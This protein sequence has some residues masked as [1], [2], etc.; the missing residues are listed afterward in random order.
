MF[1]NSFY[2]YQHIRCDTNEIIYVGKGIGKRAYDFIR[3][4]KLWLDI[5]S[6]TDIKVEMLI[7]NIE[8][9]FAILIEKE[10]ISSYLLKNISLVNIKLGG[11]SNKKYYHSEEV[12][13]KMSESHKGKKRPLEVMEKMWVANR[14]KP[15]SEQHKLNLAKSH[16]GKKLSLEHK[17]KISESGFAR[18]KKIKEN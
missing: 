7:E 11:A 17:R 6:K 18:W 16:I 2:V 12:K 14:G 13:K 1:S 5:K 8:N 4:N 3:R 15:K 10:V 9:E